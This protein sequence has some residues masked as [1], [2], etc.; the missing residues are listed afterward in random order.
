MV[1][2]GY[3]MVNHGKYIYIFFE[4]FRTEVICPLQLV[5]EYS[6][7]WVLPNLQQPRKMRKTLI[8]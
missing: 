3:Y 4:G 6:V 8:I 1:I 7:I 2:N 5:S